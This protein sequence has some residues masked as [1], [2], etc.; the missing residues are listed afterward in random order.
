[1]KIY[2]GYPYILMICLLTKNTNA[3]DMKSAVETVE[4]KMVNA[5]LFTNYTFL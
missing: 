2:M 4:N 5:K 1:M 3:K